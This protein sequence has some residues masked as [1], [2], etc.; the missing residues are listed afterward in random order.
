MM[1]VFFQLNSFDPLDPFFFWLKSSAV[2]FLEQLLFVYF[3]LI[4][5]LLFPFEKEVI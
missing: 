3:N 5:I 1:L 2:L 4:W